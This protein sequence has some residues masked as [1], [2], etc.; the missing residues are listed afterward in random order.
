M[1]RLKEER[2]GLD[3]AQQIWRRRRSH[4]C[5]ALKAKERELAETLA[6]LHDARQLLVQDT[7]NW[8]GQQESLQK[9]LHGLNNRSVH[10]RRRIQEQE[11]EIARLDGILH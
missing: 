6:K 1:R 2:R 10:Q 11:E 9:E 5:S 4:D 8:D 3:E 7:A